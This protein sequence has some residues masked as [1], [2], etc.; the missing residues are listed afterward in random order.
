MKEEEKKP[1]SWLTDI[2]WSAKRCL[3]LSPSPTYSV[4]LLQSI[5]GT[6]R[7]IIPEQVAPTT[8]SVGVSSKASREV[9]S[10]LYSAFTVHFSRS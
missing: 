2:S 8:G 9:S 5:L 4:A 7:Q 10:S 6:G 1:T 3:A